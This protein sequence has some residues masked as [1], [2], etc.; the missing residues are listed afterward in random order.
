[1]DCLFKKDKS[2]IS[3]H[4]FVQK[5]YSELIQSVRE[6]DLTDAALLF[7]LTALISEESLPSVCFSETC[8]TSDLSKK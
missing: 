8:N 2:H 5:Q 6:P 7:K 3:I 4:F 1:M